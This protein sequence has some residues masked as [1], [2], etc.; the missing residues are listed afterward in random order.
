[1]FLGLVPPCS[2]GCDKTLP[3]SLMPLARSD[4][5]GLTMY[6]GSCHPGPSFAPEPFGG[7]ELNAGSPYEV[8]CEA[9]GDVHGIIEHWQARGALAAGTLSADE[10]HHVECTCI[11][12]AGACGGM[13]TASECSHRHTHKDI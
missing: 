12:G 8:G 1:M 6:G 9:C 4:A 3:A 13:F 7:R 11:P 5:L 10:V 2:G